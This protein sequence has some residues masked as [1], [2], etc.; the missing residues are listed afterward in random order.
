MRFPFLILILSCLPV[1]GLAQS[2]SAKA[3]TSWKNGNENKAA[4]QA[5]KLLGREEDNALARCVMGHLRLEVN[6]D[7]QEALRQGLR[8]QA[9][10]RDVVTPEQRAAWKASGFGIAAI[11]DLIEAASTRWAAEVMK[12]P[13]TQDDLS[14]LKHPDGLSQEVLMEVRLHLERIE[15]ERAK[16]IGTREAF[17]EFMDVFP[18]SSWNQDALQAIQAL[19]FE[20]AERE[21][22]LMA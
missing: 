11:Q 14:L 20:E 7:P 2:T 15:F 3:W 17:Q 19:D 6:D 10:W 18:M 21:N 16:D 1:L 4:A 5:E 12:T 22:S 8:A 13:S 9:S